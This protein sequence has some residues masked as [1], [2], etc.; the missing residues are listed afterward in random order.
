[1][2]SGGAEDLED[3]V[4][5]EGGHGGRVLVDA[6]ED[7]DEDLQGGEGRAAALSVVR[8]YLGRV[9]VKKMVVKD[10]VVL[11]IVVVVVGGQVV[12][13]MLAEVLRCGSEV[14]GAGGSLFQGSLK[15]E[16][17]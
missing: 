10:V 9:V 3:V 12:V 17:L 14:G 1:M 15:R 13:A 2:E 4:G 8:Y 11:V 7:L 16:Y 6:L 5:E